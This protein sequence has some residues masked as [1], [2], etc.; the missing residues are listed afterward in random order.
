MT[1]P[2]ALPWAGI[3]QTPSAFYNEMTDIRVTAVA[4]SEGLI[5]FC[6]QDLG[7]DAPGF[8]LAPAP[9]ATQSTPARVGFP[10]I[11]NARISVRFK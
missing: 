6:C 9:R 10:R 3:W 11:I 5:I 8:M 2:R 1:L 7:A 4:R